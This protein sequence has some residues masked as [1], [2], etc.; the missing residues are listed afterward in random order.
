MPLPS[1]VLLTL[2]RKPL[3]GLVA[4][5]S[6]SGVRLNAYADDLLGRVEVA[7]EP[8]PLQVEVHSVGALGWPS[9]ATLDEVLRG[10]AARGLAPCPLEAALLLR[11]AWLGRSVSPRITVVSSRVHPDE[12]V[13][14]GFY[15]R[16]DAEGCWLRA[17]VASDDWVAG[18]D[19]RLALL[20]R[21]SQATQDAAPAPR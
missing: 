14:R 17:Y 5:L 3:S 20:R 4:A 2:G 6:R 21:P 1:P 7:A 12:A 18:P 13:P 16:D 10:V 8:A 19:E 15:L 9:G 11:L